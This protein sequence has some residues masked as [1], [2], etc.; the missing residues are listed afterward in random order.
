MWMRAGAVSSVVCGALYWFQNRAMQADTGSAKTKPCTTSHYELKL[1]QVLFRHGAR[2]PLKALPDIEQAEWVPNLLEVP[3][4]TLFDYIVTD[5][6]GGPKPPSP[7]ED[8]YRT[9]TLAGGTFPGQLT[10]LGMQQLYDLGERMRRTYVEEMPYLSP[11]FCPSE[12]Y[13]R[14][15]NIVRTIESAKCLLA[16]LFQQKQEGTVKIFTADSETEILYPNYHG[17]K[18]LRVLSSQRWAESSLLPDVAA[19]LKN[20]LNQLGVQAQKGLDFIHIRDD[21]VAREAHGLPSPAVLLSWKSTVEQRAVEM[22]HY[23]YE[24]S[25]RQNL[26]LCVGPLLHTLMNNIEEKHQDKMKSGR[27]RKLYLY[28]VHDT[29]LVPCLMALGIFDMKWPPYAADLTFELYEHCSSKEA[30]VKVSYIGQDQLVKGC[31][32]IYCPLQEFKKVLSTYTLDSADYGALC[33]QSDDVT[34]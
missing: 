23:I 18:L 33:N 9:Q 12:V 17:C 8:R 20:V 22:L 24:P 4:H 13:V 21:L 2:T 30:F 3:A 28:S 32:D 1:V 15:T 31:S 6:K 19:D 5:L 34:K 26:Q 10:T 16:G 29:T 7:V 25:K 14:S 11:I 27:S